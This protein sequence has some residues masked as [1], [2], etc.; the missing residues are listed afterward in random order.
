MNDLI[1]I[2][3]STLILTF[4]YFELYCYTS[5]ELFHTNLATIAHNITIK[6]TIFFGKTSKIFQSLQLTTDSWK[7]PISN[8]TLAQPTLN[9]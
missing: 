6:L 9:H 1:F 2:R 5:M 4:E 8:L 7:L 3:K